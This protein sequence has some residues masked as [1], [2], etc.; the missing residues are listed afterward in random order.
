M[1]ELNSQFYFDI[2]LDD[3]NRIPHVFWVNAR[4]R[5]TW[6]NFGDI[7]C[8]DTTYLSNK[9]DMPFAPFFGVNN[10]GQSVLL[11]C[12]LLSSDHTDPFALH[13]IQAPRRHCHRLM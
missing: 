6:D 1:R 13:V 7:L 11:E 12:G 5:A 8:F 2:D 10:H 4:S 9:Y 3:D